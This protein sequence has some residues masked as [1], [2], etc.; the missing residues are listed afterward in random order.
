[1]L[2]FFVRNDSNCKPF[3]NVR[4]LLSPPAFRNLWYFQTILNFCYA[5]QIIHFGCDLDLMYVQWKTAHIATFTD[6]FQKRYWHTPSN[7]FALWDPTTVFFAIHLSSLVVLRVSGPG[8]LQWHCSP[9][10]D[11]EFPLF[12]VLLWLKGT[13]LLPSLLRPQIVAVV[14]I[15]AQNEKLPHLFPTYLIILRT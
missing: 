11:F 10:V 15:H 5:H 12:G 14:P 2:L 13:W 9:V 4:V 1:M 7:Y 3:C 8:T 6:S